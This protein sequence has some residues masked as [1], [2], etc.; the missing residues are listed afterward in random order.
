MLLIPLRQYRQRFEA[1]K[2][3]W[4]LDGIVF[5]VCI[6]HR[7]GDRTVSMTISDFW[8]QAFLAALHRLPV[9]AARQEASKAT[10]ACLEYWREQ[11]NDFI[12]VLSRRQ[13]VLVTEISN[14]AQ[15]PE[16][17]P[18]KAKRALRPAASVNRQKKKR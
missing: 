6:A 13:D 4:T 10:V 8:N 16:L 14:P 18:P 1:K 7:A 11:R 5:S 2:L 9:D 12:P 15:I 17:H 3:P